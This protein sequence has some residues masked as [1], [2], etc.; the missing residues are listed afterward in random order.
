MKLIKNIFKLI[1]ISSLL[2]V[3]TL[4]GGLYYLSSSVPR[5]NSISD[6]RL[7]LPSRVYDRNGALLATFG[8][9]K[10]ELVEID[11]IPKKVLNAFLAA[12]DS[13]FYEHS[14]I[15]LFGIARAFIANL[16]A[17]RVVQGGSTITQ[18]VAKSFLSNK[19]RSVVRKMKDIILAYKLEKKLSKEEILF[20]TLIKFIWEADITEL[21]RRLR[22]IS[23]KS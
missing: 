14:G 16:K 2:G 8:T 1:L 21:K 5:I 9:E 17:G 19:E 4:V 7:K 23:V 11:E 12:E 20:F 15:D 22:V 3:F 10:R 6:Y 18:Q 13:G